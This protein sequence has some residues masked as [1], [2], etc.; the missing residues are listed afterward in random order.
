MNAQF[1]QERIKEMT[2]DVPNFK[3]DITYAIIYPT[4]DKIKFCNRSE[5]IAELSILKDCDVAHMEI[6]WVNKNM[7]AESAMHIAKCFNLGFEV[8]YD[9]VSNDMTPYQALREWDII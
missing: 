8:M 2:R 5:M 3:S 4:I 6:I 1:I 7:T 9:I